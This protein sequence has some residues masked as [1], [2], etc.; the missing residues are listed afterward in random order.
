MDEKF[1]V[2]KAIRELQYA[3]SNTWFGDF[4]KAY[5]ILGCSCFP[6]RVP[7]EIEK[8]KMELAESKSL[9]NKL[10]S[11]RSIVDREAILSSEPYDDWCNKQDEMRQLKSKVDVLQTRIDFMQY[12]RERNAKELNKARHEIE[13]L[14]KQVV[15]NLNEIERLKIKQ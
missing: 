4:Q 9:C 11:D 7:E 5:T 12:E 14:S 1:D 6:S 13:I 15:D 10:L 3:K 2:E 8:L